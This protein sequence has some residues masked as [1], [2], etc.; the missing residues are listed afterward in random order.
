MIE[1]HAFLLR[2]PKDETL[3]YKIIPSRYFIDMLENN[4][5]YFRKVDTYH[6]DTRDGD[7]PD[8]DKL[9][10]ENKK[11][12]LHSG[13]TLKDYYSDARSKTYACC[14]STQNTQF[15]WEHYS[16]GD[17]NAICLV[18]DCRKL[19]EYI[20]SVYMNAF[21]IVN[22]NRY[23]NF[24]FINYGLVTYG[25][26]DQL[27]VKDNFLNPIEY[28]YFKDA[29]K[30]SDEDEFRITLSCIGMFKYQLDGRPF[31]FPESLKLEFNIR[32]VIA[33][34]ILKEILIASGHDEDLRIKLQAATNI[35]DES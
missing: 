1:P 31:A 6:D 13:Y 4:Y 21:L 19:I 7:Q 2:K 8:A 12:Q 30:Y 32:D 26:M 22:N 34:K 14:F 29:N 10:S 33:N 3:L 15:L 20:N 9:I 18:L 35:I 17:K 24:L 16:H 23:K 5:I 25:N 28:A 11:F 27:F